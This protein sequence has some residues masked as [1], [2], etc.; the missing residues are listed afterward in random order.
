MILLWVCSQR[1]FRLC[2]SSG[3]TWFNVYNNNIY[4]RTMDNKRTSNGSFYSHCSFFL[5]GFLLI[6]SVNK[7]W[8]SLFRHSNFIGASEDIN[9]VVVGFL[10]S[11]LCDPINNY[12]DFG[13]VI[14]GLIGLNI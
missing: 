5:L 7:C 6:L 8:Q 11:A 14:T 13:I 10:L 2:R 3:S 9:A 4:G 12:L 1:L